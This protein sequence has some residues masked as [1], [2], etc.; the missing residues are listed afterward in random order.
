MIE[1]RSLIFD[2]DGTLVD[3]CADIAA[4]LNYTLE[5][6]HYPP[7]SKETV[8]KIVGDGVRTLL[9]RATGCSEDSF[10]NSAIDIFKSHYRQHYV[11]QTTLYPHVRETLD[12]F[13]DK[14]MAVVSNKPY[15]MVEKTLVHFGIRGRFEVVLGPEST[16]ERKPHPEPILKSLEALQT[17]PNQSLLVG[18][19]TTD[20]QAGKSAGIWTCAATYGYRPKEE[21]ETLKPDFFIH[22]IE[23]LKNIIV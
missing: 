8:Q 22:G 15:E 18:D 14:K 17:P 7:L 21:L 5:Q 4:S 3:S 11:D 1:V 16:Q 12:Y 6:V 2:L 9:T 10:L 13:R 19:S 23:E 20:I